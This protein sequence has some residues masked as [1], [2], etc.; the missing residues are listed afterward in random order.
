MATCPLWIKK[1]SG[2]ELQASDMQD[3][4][5]GQTGSCS[6]QSFCLYMALESG[7]GIEPQSFLSAEHIV[8]VALSIETCLVELKCLV[9]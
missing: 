7:L 4:V 9:D 8:S 3:C 2:A 1:L 6:V 5:G